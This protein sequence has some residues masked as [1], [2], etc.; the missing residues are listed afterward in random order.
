MLNSRIF[1]LL[2][3]GLVLMRCISVKIIVISVRQKKM[4]SLSARFPTFLKIRKFLL[5]IR[6]DFL[7][8]RNFY[9]VEILSEPNS[10]TIV[11]GKKKYSK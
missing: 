6:K 10:L 1:W 9:L 5:D 4:F 8:M 2:F 3:F 7:I 11:T